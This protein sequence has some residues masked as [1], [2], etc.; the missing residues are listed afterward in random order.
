M[1]QLKADN[2]NGSLGRKNLSIHLMSSAFNSTIFN[3][4]SFLELTIS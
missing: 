2:N 1:S 3:F 4:S